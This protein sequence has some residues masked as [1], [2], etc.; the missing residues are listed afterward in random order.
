MADTL[1]IVPT[2]NEIESLE[3]LVGR[4]RQAV[5]D[6]DVLIVDDASPDG[7]GG[8]ADRLAADD[9]A[10]TVL[11]RPGKQGL[12]RA[13]LEGFARA[14]DRGYEYVVEIDADGSHDPVDLVPMLA[15]ARGA[16][17]VIG[18]RWVPGGEVR[19][20]PWPRRLI[21]RLGNAYARRVLRSR[22]RDITAGFRVYRATALRALELDRVSSQGYCFQVEM[23]WRVELSG[24]RVLE[25]PIAF[26]ER[27]DGR[28][29]MHA[30]I[31]AEA[32]VRVTAWAVRGRP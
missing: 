19:N 6:A 14:F 9:A 1:V 28:S 11:H 2:Y 27:A 3:R 20:W 29:K 30:G 32:L 26:V 10:I 15:L 24:G 12:G 18:S 8:L 16:D 7:T 21:S 4:V 23:A 22:I 25:H 5:P 31:V 17:L 13:Y